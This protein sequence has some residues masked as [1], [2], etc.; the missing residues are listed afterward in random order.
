MTV[1]FSPKLR[2]AVFKVPEAWKYADGADTVAFLLE[3]EATAA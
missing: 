1:E 2:N 3:R